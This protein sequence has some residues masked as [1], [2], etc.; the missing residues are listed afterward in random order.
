LIRTVPQGVQPE[1]AIQGEELEWL[2]ERIQPK[3]AADSR[4]IFG[5]LGR[6]ELREIAADDDLLH[7]FRRD[8]ALCVV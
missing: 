5:T 1:L 7:H 6:I 4:V 2:G 3:A 8:R